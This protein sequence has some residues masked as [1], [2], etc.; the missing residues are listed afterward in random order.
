MLELKVQDGEKTIVLQFE[1]S[2]RSL[3]KW[4]SKHQKAWAATPVKEHEELIDYFGYMLLTSGYDNTVIYKLSPEQL[5]SLTKYI[6]DPQTASSVP[7]DPEGRRS[8]EVVT[9]ELV[10]TWMTLL[11][12]NWEAQDWH[13]NRLMMLISMINYKK[14]PEKKVDKGRLLKTWDQINAAN[15]KRFNSKG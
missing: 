8:G 13:Y 2:L 14:Q 15:K 4:E 5:D 6:N 7:P 12:I 1:H 3:S 9:T 10:Y 11:E